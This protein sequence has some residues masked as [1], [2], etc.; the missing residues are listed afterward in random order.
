MNVKKL[1]KSPI[2]WMVLF[3]I[4]GLIVIFVLTRPKP[5]PTPITCK[6]D[7]TR[8][9]CDGEI[10]CAPNCRDDQYFNCGTRKCDCKSP[11]K[12]C[13]GGT[14]CCETCDND[15]CCAADRQIMVDGK[16]SCCAPGTYPDADTKTKCLT[17]CGIEGGPCGLN[18]TC[19]KLSGLT[20][21]RYDAFVKE[22]SSDASWRGGKWDDTSK[23]GEVY[24]CSDPPKCMWAESQALPHAVGDAYANYDMSGLS[25]E[26][27]NSLC[28][29]KDGD[30]SCYGKAQSSCD[31]DKCDWVNVLDSYSKDTYGTE[32]KLN[33]WNQQ[34]GRSVL[35]YYCG[36]NTK[37]WGRL[38][39]VVKD[40]ASSK[41]TWQDCYNRLAN[42]GT[43]DVEWNE[44]K[45][46]CSALKS[47]NTNSGIQSMVKCIG[48]GNPCPTCTKADE[49][50]RCI[51]CNSEGNP[52]KECESLGQYVSSDNCTS[53]TGWKFEPCKTDNNNVLKY[54]S[55]QEVVGNCPWGCND[56][57]SQ[58]CKN[59]IDD[60]PYVFGQALAGTSEVCYNDGQV[61][62][63]NP[64]YWRASAPPSAKACSE[65]NG[66]NCQNPG[67]AICKSS[68]EPC[69][70]GE[71]GCYATQS[72]CLE[73]N[74]CQ[75]GWLRNNDKTDCNVFQCTEDGSL[76]NR[77]VPVGQ[78]A[79][80]AN[81]LFHVN[82]HGGACIR[83]NPK[84]NPN[85]RDYCR[86]NWFSCAGSV[87]EDKLGKDYKAK[88]SYQFT[89]CQG[90]ASDT[91]AR[92]KGTAGGPDYK[93]AYT[94]VKD[95]FR[96][97][98]FY[99]IDDPDNKTKQAAKWG[100]DTA[101]SAH[102]ASALSIDAPP[103]GV[104]KYP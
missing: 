88:C 94:T 73:K 39:K 4:V 65:E 15:T 42:T 67:K 85:D 43:V 30:T 75:P 11:N 51:Q 77:D 56:P 9:S 49:Y 62:N 26:G 82:D 45:G 80:N 84:V 93:F 86:V 12:L 25:G 18:Q 5:Q 36:D 20:K 92:F 58:Q 103:D 70:E 54:D 40:T 1:I 89:D 59:T 53:T 50:A 21:E 63:F 27:F 13:E 14:V 17:V 2:V 69:G 104:P 52:C 33:K 66:D 44:E 72:E 60:A 78:I 79:N 101:G 38:E 19:N 96:S 31:S 47:G 24:F 48:P 8:T 55:T 97:G 87:N 76:A 64:N 37:S 68:K 100:G 74:S 22:H 7:E 16:I 23:S 46:T 28:L 32:D 98:D 91:I 90:T 95:N 3:I 71:K 81:D 102:T 34:Y 35:G 57:N 41:C 99:T 29:P 83:T 61:K 10:V 6:D